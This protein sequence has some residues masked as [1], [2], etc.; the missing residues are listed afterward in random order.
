MSWRQRIE[1]ACAP[2]RLDDEIVE[3]LALH[4]EAAYASARADRCDAPEAERR[5][6]AL[7]AAW[8][9]GPSRL[10]RRPSAL[11]AYLYGVTPRDAVSSC[12]SRRRCSSSR[13]L[14][15]SGRPGVRPGSI[16]CKYCAGEGLRNCR[17]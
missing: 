13:P 17:L 6:D 12:R 8:T 10:R 2:A 5:V 9:G 11:Q 14:P 16:R 4:A 1:S 3:E 7:I 15:A